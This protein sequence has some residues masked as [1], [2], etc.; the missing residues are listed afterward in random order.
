M[1]ADYL[2]VHKLLWKGTKEVSWWNWREVWH[3]DYVWKLHT[4]VNGSVRL[5]EAGTGNVE[6]SDYV[7][8][9]IASVDR[10]LVDAKRSNDWMKVLR[11]PFVLQVSDDLIGTNDACRFRSRCMGSAKPFYQI[12]RSDSHW[13]M[14]GGCVGNAKTG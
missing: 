2:T 4:G 9:R 5:N 6:G 10:P 12:G 11:Q 3:F 1:V 8:E 13:L 14:E 7:A